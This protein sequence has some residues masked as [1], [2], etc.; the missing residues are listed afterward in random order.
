MPDEDGTASE[1]AVRETKPRHGRGA[2]PH[3]GHAAGRTSGA[4]SGSG[5]SRSTRSAGD[6]AGGNDTDAKRSDAKR[7][8]TKRTGAGDGR[9][10]RPDAGAARE[11]RG[12]AAA[13]KERPQPD[14]SAQQRPDRSDGTQRARSGSRGQQPDRSKARTGVRRSS[15]EGSTHRDRGL[16]SGTRGARTGHS[17][18]S[19]RSGH[20]PRADRAASGRSGRRGSFGASDQYSAART[21]RT[22]RDPV[23]PDPQLPEDLDPRELPGAARGELKTLSKENAD[24]VAR[25]LVMA[26]RVIDSDPALAHAH[27]QA[28]SRRAGRVAVVRETLG[29]TAYSIGDFALAL[30]ELRTYRRISGSDDEIALMVDS[31]R[32]LGRPEKALALGRAVDRSLLPA[33]VRVE[34]AIAMSGARL[35]VGENDRALQELDIP[36]LDPD[37]AHEWSPALFAARA[38]VLEELGRAQEAAQWRARANIAAEAL[39][40]ASAHAETIL[41][42]EIA[43][44]SEETDSTAVE[45]T[46]DAPDTV[47]DAG[48]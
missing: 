48:N 29:I 40:G 16:S 21:T 10:A 8:S 5:N 45:R 46:G 17:G 42:E 25:H 20:P 6:R 33:A 22:D 9:R 41:V 23:V 35:D 43:E 34:L 13:G 19:D 24:R 4:G 18:R 47:E 44:D 27:A 36:E 11:G 39:D 1:D 28:A 15:Q 2:Q 7:S 30:R 31:E 38:T 14:R 32:G 26:A 12:T 37:R 3:G